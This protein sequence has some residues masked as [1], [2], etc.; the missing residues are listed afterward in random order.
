MN[1]SDEK[2]RRI[3]GLKILLSKH[4]KIRRLKRFNYPELHGNKVWSSS[5]ILIDYIKNSGIRRKARVLEVGCGWGLPGI[6]CAKNFDALVTGV[7]ADPEV[8]PYLQLH[9]DINKVQIATRKATFN[10][11]NKNVLKAHEV[12]IASDICFWDAMV[13]PLKNLIGRAIKNGVNVIIA[14]PGRESFFECVN[15]F[16]NKEKGELLNW[17]IKKSRCIHGHIFKSK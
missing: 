9:A 6:F 8:F 15:S 7:D 12:L 4:P 1:N 2:I 14:D 11:L 5:L 16:I 10:G 13:K 3:Y 17:Q